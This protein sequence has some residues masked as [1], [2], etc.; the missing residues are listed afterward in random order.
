MKP[1]NPNP[2]TLFYFFQ[3]YGPVGKSH[4]CWHRRQV[5]SLLW[6]NTWIQGHIWSKGKCSEMLTAQLWALSVV[7]ADKMGI[8]GCLQLRAGLNHH[9][10]LTLCSFDHS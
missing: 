1:D 6:P 10:T 3:K 4:I 7:D 5:E 9:F 2:L 8:P